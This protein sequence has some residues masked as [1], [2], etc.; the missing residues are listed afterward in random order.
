MN[1]ASLP[2]DFVTRAKRLLAPEVRT[3][4][5]RETLLG[6]SFF[7][8]PELL[9]M[10][11]YDIDGNTFASHCAQ[12]LLQQ[13]C[14]PN[15]PHPLAILLDTIR[16]AKDDLI[17]AEID[18]LM[19]LL[20]QACAD[21]SPTSTTRPTLP[22]DT[23]N[24]APPAHPTIRSISVDTPKAERQPSVFI[25]YSRQ[26]SD[27]AQRLIETLQAAG[28]TCWIDTSAIKGGDEWM[29]AI[30]EG[31]NNSYAVLV[32]CSAAALR[33]RWVREEFLWAKQKDKRILP[34]LLEDVTGDNAFFGLHS[35]QAVHWP[36]GAGVPQ[37]VLAALQAP[38]R[39]LP[40]SAAS[41]ARIMAA[42][43]TLELEYLDRLRLEEFR[44]VSKYTPLAGTAQ[45]GYAKSQRAGVQPVV[46]SQRYAHT[47]WSNAET[48]AH[49]TRHFENALDELLQI[50]RAVVLGEPGA[51]KSSTLWTLASHLVDQ[52]AQDEQQP[53]PFLIRLG[54]WTRAEQTLPDFIAGELGGLGPFA[55]RLLQDQRAALLLDGLNELPVD[56]RG[57]KFAQVAALLQAHANSIAILTCRERD[58]TVDLGLDRVVITPLEPLRIREFAQRYLGPEPGETLFWKLTGD[59]KPVWEKWQRAGATFAQFF[60]A[61][62]VPKENP[63][64]YSNTSGQDDEQW[65]KAIRDK[66]SLIELARN[67]YM[68]FMLTQLYEERGQLPANRGE[69]FAGFALRLLRRE[70]LA[71]IDADKAIRPTAEGASLLNGLAQ[72]AYTMQLQRGQQ[73]A[74]A[75]TVLTADQARS[76]LS[77][78]Q[79]AQAQ[80][81]NLVEIGDGVRFGHQLLQEYFAARYMQQ[82]VE[83]GRL[84][85]SDLWKPDQW[86]ARTNWEEATILLAGLCSN[87]CSVILKWA[88]TANP[89][90][91]AQCINRSGAHTPSETL[92]QLRN[93]WLPR[94]TDL[95]SDPMPEARAAI[96][97]AIGQLS[98]INGITMDTRKGV[99]N[100]NGVPDIDWVP[101]KA[102]PFL[103][104]EKKDKQTLKQDFWIARYPVTYA[105]FQTFID[106]S[107]GF[108][109]PRWWE[110]LS[111]SDDHRANPGDQA[112]KYWNH[113]CERVS[114]YDAVAFSRWLSEKLGY[115]MRLPTEHEWERAARGPQGSDYAYA[116]KYDEEKANTGQ[117]IGQTTAVGMY[118]NSVTA[119][120]IADVTGN[121]WEWCLNEYNNPTNI[122]LG[123]DSARVLRGGSWSYFQVFARGAYRNNYDPVSRS[124]NIGFRV[125]CVR[126]LV[127]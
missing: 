84:K 110:G 73:E 112:F 32:L 127:L 115:E 120:G 41:Y 125:V 42:P 44:Q 77:D 72:L 101:I 17:C 21:P 25:C 100:R 26:D 8:R 79:R 34:V 98:P 65:R 71:E 19:E 111:A 118:P 48:H 104:G 89:E 92:I 60:E 78:Q 117:R 29:R 45:M 18:T 24:T 59:L 58:Y 10:F 4:T 75:L 47:P 69:L 15:Q 28:H 52:A 39:I 27:A 113:P 124:I 90:V 43:R 11:N 96:G 40:E 86:W 119:E 107:D 83:S 123:G 53:I 87:D 103:Y 85:A 56:Q 20:A 81:A 122:K 121:V 6:E 126:P 74:G 36:Q 9:G 99:G 54:N 3:L 116:G 88:A 5:Q 49:E 16:F 106:A 105:Q 55:Q 2:S 13:S 33:S 62:D 95:K 94:L 37:T 114:W 63:N 82:E 97:R 14:S 35:S 70:G 38:V 108:R 12:K 50:R 66:G 109:N 64:V 68:L 76:Y 93:A 80:S 31:I 23:R 1:I 46:M 22:S 51:G 102:G 91:A 61:P 7:G 67:P 30:S 57:N